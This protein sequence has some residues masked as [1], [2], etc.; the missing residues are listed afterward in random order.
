MEQEV[1]YPSV[2]IYPHE[3]AAYKLTVYM[4]ICRISN[5]RKINS[6][7]CASTTFYLV[8]PSFGKMQCVVG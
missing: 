7:P 6:Y 8:F 3:V 5:T 2:Y 1:D 4:L